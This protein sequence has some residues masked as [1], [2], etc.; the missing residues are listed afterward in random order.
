MSILIKLL[1]WP[2][3]SS[4]FLNSVVRGES[5]SFTI[6]FSTLLVCS[7]SSESL[8]MHSLLG[9]SSKTI[10][11]NQG[12]LVRPATL[13]LLKITFCRIKKAPVR[14]RLIMKREAHANCLHKNYV[15][16]LCQ[17]MSTL[18][19]IIFYQLMTLTPWYINIVIDLSYLH[20]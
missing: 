5:K 12:D 7:T 17:Y 20:R 16:V 2:S 18:V 14:C 4:I 13:T 6:S 10:E 19:V 15:Q 3:F 9:A 1:S 11:I 8:V